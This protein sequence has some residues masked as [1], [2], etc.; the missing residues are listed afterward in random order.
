MVPEQEM[1]QSQAGS[2][3]RSKPM[4]R[5]VDE[6]WE[7]TGP[8]LTRRHTQQWQALVFLHQMLAQ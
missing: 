2:L 1:G 7:V 3:D 8:N 4:I 6:C 5:Y